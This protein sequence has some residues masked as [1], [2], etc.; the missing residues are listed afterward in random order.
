MPG[1]AALKLARRG[2]RR[3]QAHSTIGIGIFVP[4]RTGW[5]GR[6]GRHVLSLCSR[7]KLVLGRRRCDNRPGRLNL[8]RGRLH[9]AG[10]RAVGRGRAILDG[11]RRIKR[12]R[13]G[14]GFWRRRS[15]HLRVVAEL[16]PGQQPRSGQATAK[17]QHVRQEAASRFLTALIAHEELIRPCSDCACRSGLLSV[18]GR[19]VGH[20]EHPGDVGIRVSSLMFGDLA[21]MPFVQVAGG[22]VGLAHER[23][24]W[25]SGRLAALG[26]LSCGWRTLFVTFLSLVRSFRRLGRRCG[27]WDRHLARDGRLRIGGACQLIF[28]QHAS[29]GQP[30]TQKE[31]VRQEA[32]P[33][34]SISTALAH[35]SSFRSRL[36]SLTRQ[37]WEYA[38][39]LRSEAD[40][41]PA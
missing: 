39:A 9:L 25:F 8:G 19:R 10:I 6:R 28:G 22:R 13:V 24:G 38:G 29:R 33:T 18:S 16:G 32:P 15:P 1:C 34:F 41:E 37:R 31:H 35:C 12:S 40:S 30:P 20:H 36:R 7:G 3:R 21:A 11:R 23:V 4:G 17:K 27:G 14:S 2:R 5:G 26:S